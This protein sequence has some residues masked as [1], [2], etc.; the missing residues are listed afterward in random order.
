[1]Y[2]LTNVIG[3]STWF[4]GGYFD[5]DKKF[6][7]QLNVSGRFPTS[8]AITTPSNCYYIV[9]NILVNNNLV[10]VNQVMMSLGSIAI[11]YEPFET[12]EVVDYEIVDDDMTY[13]QISMNV[14]GDYE[15]VTTQGYQLFDASKL[16]TTSQG[17]AT[18]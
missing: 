8:G 9:L 6:I 16:P 7:S 11:N 4:T 17:G 3:L 18:L 10:D 15:Q 12:I 14:D 1:Q 2:Y 13:P 5:K